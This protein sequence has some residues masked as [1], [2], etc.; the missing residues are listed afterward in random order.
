MKLIYIYTDFYFTSSLEIK[1][2]K[3][4]SARQTAAQ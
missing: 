4:R 1:H 2:E 3:R